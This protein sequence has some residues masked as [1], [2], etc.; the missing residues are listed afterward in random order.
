MDAKDDSQ[1]G[2]TLGEVGELE[3]LDR[4][5]RRLPAGDP[6]IGP[7][8]DCAV[9]AAP[10]GRYVVT[11]DMMVHG[12]DF[13]WAWSSP[14]DIGW[15]AAATNLS[16]VAAMG[17][18]PTGLVIALAAPQDTPV[19]V[20]ERVADGV[21]LAAEALAPA[22]GVVGGDLS[23][24]STFTVA[25]TAFG[26]L[27]GRAPVLRSGAE[28]G[29]VVTVS[30]ELGRAAR[31]LARLFRDGVDAAGEPSRAAT[32]ASGADADPDVLRQRRPVPPIADGVAAAGAGATAMLDL[33]DGLAIDGGRLARA[34]RVTLDLDPTV[35]EEG[36]A[37]HGGEDHGLL[38]TFPPGMPLPAGFRRIGSVRE[39]GEHDVLRGG[40]PVPTTGW[41]PYADWDG[42]AG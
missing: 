8:D 1:P 26:D 12:P 14:E 17:A 5:V 34:S 42:A 32:V 20:L 23:T 33:S 7:G 39:R 16:D 6:V 25:V 2:P 31:G 40:R 36:P 9:L 41:D 3:V 37:L 15:K 21:R 11:T 19:S 4:I 22:C 28:P 18:T 27:G 13:R 35:V 24:S 10:D 38:A 30:G 29:D